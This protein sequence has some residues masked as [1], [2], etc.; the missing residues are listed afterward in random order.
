[1]LSAITTIKKKVKLLL[2]GNRLQ[3]SEV[4]FSNRTF[5]LLWEVL[6]VIPSNSTNFPILPS[7]KTE[8]R[9]SNKVVI[10][11]FKFISRL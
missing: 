8:T 5:A 3:C 7:N 4:K 1:M 11:Q 2:L 9:Q 10:V 6:G